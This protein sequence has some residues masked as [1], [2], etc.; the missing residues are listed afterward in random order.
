MHRFP[1]PLDL[2]RSKR[3]RADIPFA[4]G[5][6]SYRSVLL[7]LQAAGARADGVPER[8]PRARRLRCKHHEEHQPAHLRSGAH[9]M[10]V[11]RARR[12]VATTSVWWEHV[13]MQFQFVSIVFHF[14][15]QP[16]PSIHTVSVKFQSV[17]TTDSM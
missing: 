9:G 16:L 10:S 17:T 11:A 13:G 3:C 15:L 7:V 1:F 6:V 12:A 5:T 8:P 4:R 2:Q 14:A